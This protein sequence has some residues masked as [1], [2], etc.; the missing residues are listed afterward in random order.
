MKYLA[1]ANNSL[2]V[3]CVMLLVMYVFLLCDTV[4]RA[5]Q[6]TE[7]QR[8]SRELENAVVALEHTYVEKV[9]R[10]HTLDYE[11]LGFEKP[12]SIEYITR[13]TFTLER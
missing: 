5:A 12:L 4:Y 3:L 7:Y 8:A 9:Q 6:T 1:I 11:A 2:K 10:I 13:E